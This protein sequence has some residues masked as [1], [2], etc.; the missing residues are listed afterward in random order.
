MERRRKNDVMKLHLRRNQTVDFRACIGSG[1][2]YHGVVQYENRTADTNAVTSKLLM[3]TSSKHLCSVLLLLMGVFS[4]ASAQQ[5]GAATDGLTIRTTS[6]P[7]AF[8]RQ[9]YRQQLQAS[10]GVQPYRWQ[11][12]DGKLP[13]GITLRP[14]GW[15]EGNAKESGEFHITVTVIDGNKPPQERTQEF[16]LKVFVP[17]LAQWGR[18]PTIDVHRIE[19]SVKVSNQSE[20]DLDLTF[21]V[22]AVNEIGRA[23]AIGYQRLTL[24]RDT[25]ELEL[26][27]GEE[28]PAGSYEIHVDVVGEVAAANSIYRAHLVGNE[29][30]QI[31]QGP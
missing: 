3:R 10:G 14:D 7:R 20:Q 17:L 4:A 27:F 30:L 18:Y 22:L 11:I 21:V 5:I 24:R 15:L 16:V 25:A 31:V 8:A 26:P 6:L 29:K 13:D 28:L 1:E 9:D 19:G 12:D 2:A 23:T